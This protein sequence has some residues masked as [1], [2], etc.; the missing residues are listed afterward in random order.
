MRPLAV[1]KYNAHMHTCTYA[2]VVVV[3]MV[4]AFYE[5]LK[6]CVPATSICVKCFYFSV[7]LMQCTIF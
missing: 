3:V 6:K 7:S 2:L 1:I 4:L 5:I